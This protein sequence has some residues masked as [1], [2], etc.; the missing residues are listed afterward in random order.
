MSRI[1]H[2]LHCK[3][4]IPFLIAFILAVAFTGGSASAA[5]ALS[6]VP[7]S[8][9]NH[10]S[11]PLCQKLGKTFEGS[12]G[13][14]MW[15]FGEQPNGSGQALK[16]RALSGKSGGG[17][18]PNVD[19][20]N[21]AEDVSASG[22]QAFGQSETSIAAT[23]P[24]VVEGWNDATT[25][26]SSCGAA[27]NKEEGTGLGFSADGG[28]TFTDEG[29]LPNANCN[30][31]LYGGDPSVEAWSPGGT[32]YFYV[33]SLY[34]P[35]FSSPGTPSGSPAESRSFVALDACKATGT[36][37]SALLSCGQPVLVAA[38]SQCIS[39]SGGGFACSFLDKDFMSIDPVRGR[40]YMSFTEFFFN[41]QTGVQTSTVELAVC[42]IG[43]STGG[44]GTAGGSAGAPVC[45]NGGR[46]STLA[47]ASPYM[48]VAPNDIHGCENEGAYPAVD[49]AT[50]DVYVAYE[51]NWATSFMS[52]PG[53]LCTSLPV[54][55]VV[56]YI[57]FSC[58]TLAPRSACALPKTTNGVSVTSMEAAFIPGYSRFPMNDFPRIAVSD[59]AGTVSIVWNDARFHPAGD[60]LMQSFNLASLTAVQTA[61]PVVI[62]SSGGGWHFLP[63]LRNADANGNLNISFYSRS[64]ANTA[65]TDLVVA[66][67]VDPKATSTPANVLV[68]D[69]PSDWSSVSS[70][71]NPNFGDY[72]DTYVIATPGAPFTGTTV[73][74]AWSDGRIGDPQPFSSAINQ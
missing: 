9:T 52:F 10:S 34:N 28:A 33:S 5:S 56:N 44:A 67:A 31:A 26:V 59:S 38:S 68:T 69:T 20:A 19:A 3:S 30:S 58:L 27:M 60:I 23:G 14:Q 48:V 66:L 15:C 43:T 2:F 40:L 54:Q 6:A 18:S 32:S 42:D 37:S 70:D 1:L 46:G 71:I 8:A 35:T 39:F 24:Y 62:N 16:T 74:A 72:T 50:G 29:G 73:F 65:V 64:S 51:H 57:P 49:V 25:F 21:P 17:A 36:G 4:T 22:V 53:N 11:N 63:G 41:F 55:E 47:P 45:F 13:M 61:G 12:S 7:A